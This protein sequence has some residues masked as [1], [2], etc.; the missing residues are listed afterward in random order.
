MNDITV[1]QKQIEGLLGEMR[2]L[3][4]PRS[5]YALTHFV[6]GQHDLPGAQRKQI[7]DELQ[8]MMFS[9]GDVSD[10]KKLAEIDLAEALELL[11]RKFGYEREREEIRIGGLRRKILSIEMHLEGRLRECETLLAM[12]DRIP[13]YTREQYEAEEPERWARRLTRQFVL[14]QR[15]DFGNLDALLQMATE[16]GQAKPAFPVNA[17]VSTFLPEVKNEHADRNLPAGSSD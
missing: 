11:D 13:R 10:E 2:E 4:Q 6:V 14:H 1:T 15:G 17:V 16:P 7:L 9:L 3:G 8:A 12:L 5:D